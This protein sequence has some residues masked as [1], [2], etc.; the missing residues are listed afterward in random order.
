MVLRSFCVCIN[1]LCAC[2]IIAGCSSNSP[3]GGPDGGGI[4]GGGIDGGGPDGGGI[5]LHCSGAA[6]T[7][8]NDVQPIVGSGCGASEFCHGISYS[9]A[10]QTR[11]FLVG[12]QTSQCTDHRLR[13][14][15]GDPAHSY[16]VHKLTDSDLCQG[17]PM[18]KGIDGPWQPLDADK[19]QTIYDWICSGAK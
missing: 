6:P 9:S 1:L 12:Q 19:L 2:I 5:N 18:P 4:D 13:V 16:L 7:L 14:A 11:N 15:P 8:A 17:A 3:S 10:A